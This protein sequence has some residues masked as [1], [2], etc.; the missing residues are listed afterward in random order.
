LSSFDGN[1]NYY[2]FIDLDFTYVLSSGNSI[3]I[4]DYG[5]FVLGINFYILYGSSNSVNISDYSYLQCYNMFIGDQQNSSKGNTINI[6]NNS[7]LW[8]QNNNGIGTN[9]VV[10]SSNVININNN[11]FLFAENFILGQYGSD[12]T[13]NV[14]SN[15]PYANYIYN[16]I[17]TE[18]ASGLNTIG[19]FYVSDSNNVTTNNNVIITDS[20]WYSYSLDGSTN[21]I[22]VGNL[23]GANGN[24]ILNG[25][26]QITSECNILGTT[27][28]SPLLI[29]IYNG[30]IYI[31]NTNTQ[32]PFEFDTTLCLGAN[33]TTN[34]SL[35]LPTNYSIYTLGLY[36]GANSSIKN[37]TPNQFIEVSSFNSDSSATSYIGFSENISLDNSP[38][39]FIYYSAST[40]SF[41]ITF[42]NQNISGVLFENN[43]NTFTPPYSGTIS[44]QIPPN[45][46]VT[47]SNQSIIETNNFNLNNLNINLSEFTISNSS[48]TSLSNSFIAS[49]S[50]LY[51]V[52]NGTLL[53]SNSTV[54]SSSSVS[55][56]GSTLNA[57]NIFFDNNNEDKSFYV[58][59]STLS[60]SN[61][62]VLGSN[63]SS[64]IM[65]LL[66]NTNPITVGSNIIVGLGATNSTS[67]ANSLLL[68]DNS[69]LRISNS[70][71]TTAPPSN[72][73]LIVGCYAS[74]DFLIITNGGSV[75]SSLAAIG[76]YSTAVN[77]T[78][79]V[80]GTN[81]LWNNSN[82]FYVGFIGGKSSL[83]IDNGGEVLVHGPYTYVGLS[84][85]SNA[86]DI[87]GSSSLFSN[88]GA[89]NIGYYGSHNS[90]TISNG[91]ALID[92]NIVNNLTYA[93]L[94]GA[95]SNNNSVTIG[96]NS[97]WTN[98]GDLYIGFFG[99]YNS[100]TNN[101][102][103]LVASNIYLGRSNTIKNYSILDNNLL[104][105]NGGLLE[106]V[107]M[108]IGLNSSF[109]TMSNTTSTI[110]GS[111]TNYGYISNAGV[112][113][114]GYFTNIGKGTNV[115]NAIKT[116]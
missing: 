18:F 56:V 83:F 39:T 101:G 13:I 114:A 58:S 12:N 70:N 108:T 4:T 23:N 93:A 112:I 60:V 34:A 66:N 105:E 21:T 52:S 9:A 33:G 62:L 2:G 8:N 25:T 100:V 14:T 84:A 86:V 37:L 116:L 16:N 11:G 106:A 15:S 48:T 72:Y 74:S 45:T 31:N 92:S 95:Y 102:G 81:S 44:M 51:I 79:I 35:Y 109:L 22:F 65:Y 64:S 1:P 28:I 73:S 53:A 40:N 110:S 111:I 61:S 47:I 78:A 77:N 75:F 89:I 27:Y 113:N 20:T 69:T 107:N 103:N 99:S 82:S 91:A 54:Q 17:L 3:N 98:Y 38:H 59:D 88:Q 46:N 115:G 90:I 63:S 41:Q 67:S 80:N 26:G 97:S 43:L 30:N 19:N 57:Q 55:L 96:S 50:I 6:S 71:I 42:T 36:L 85:S 87:N 68:I 29:N 10:S 32:A 94:L 24:I 76:Y 7:Y 5:Y 104:I 49:E